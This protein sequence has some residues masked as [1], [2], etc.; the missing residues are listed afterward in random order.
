[1]PDTLHSTS[2][3]PPRAHVTV[4]GAVLDRRRLRFVSEPLEAAGHTV[5]VLAFSP[6]GAFL[7]GCARLARGGRGRRTDAVILVG[8]GPKALIAAR[9]ARLAGVPLIA[10]LG[11]DPVRDARTR[12]A[13]A[14]AQGRWKTWAVERLNV[15]VRRRLMRRVDALIVVNASML[16]PLR[17]ELGDVP[18]HVVPQF[19]PGEGQARDGYDL[20]DPVRLLTVT[21]L[22]YPAKAEGVVWLVDALAAMVRDGA[23]AM[24]LDV[25][26]GGPSLPALQAALGE[27]DLPAGLSVDVKGF[28]DDVAALYAGADIFVY[29]S[30]HDATPNVFLEAK[31]FG[32]PM[33]V[34]ACEEF[35]N[36]VTDEV[37][38]LLYPDA[39]GFRARM[40]RLLGD[41]DLRARLGTAALEDHD[42]RFSAAAAARLLEQALADLGILARAKART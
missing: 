39:D 8:L 2:A 13:Q 28:V 41:A 17:A 1:M 16:A 29:R 23:P 25:A 40:Q 21:N 26:G 32:L 24:H 12:A 15:A 19:C 36:I 22:A 37:S 30:D 20:C 6:L 35:A 27:R 38:G 11:G 10:R 33:L 34:N 5:D 4:V 42:T 31:R 18:V 7:K 9:A 14:R 3:S